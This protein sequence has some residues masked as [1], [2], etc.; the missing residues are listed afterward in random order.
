MSK[1]WIGILPYDPAARL[2]KSIQ[3][4]STLQILDSKPEQYPGFRHG[5]QTSLPDPISL[6][7]QLTTRVEQA[8][9]GISRV[10]NARFQ[11]F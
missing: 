3:P 1:P 4:T 6:R 11:Q 2:P 10:G 5:L 7:V 9:A 8:P